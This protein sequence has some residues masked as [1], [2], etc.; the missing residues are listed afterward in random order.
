MDQ[1][2][3]KILRLIIPG[4]IIFAVGYFFFQILTNNQLKEL[5]FSEFGIQ[6]LVA[7][8]IGALY[9]TFNLR[10]IITNYTHKKI[11]LNIKNHIFKLYVG[12]L[13][14]TQIQYLF[15]QNRLKNVFYKIVDNDP[16]LVAKGKNVYFNGLLCT[17]FADSFIITFL[18]SIFVLIFTFFNDTNSEELLSYSFILFLIAIGSI[19]FHIIAFFNHTKISNTQIEFIEANYISDVK[20]IIDNI[21]R[22]NNVQ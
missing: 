8:V 13:S 10:F 20:K 15:K 22:E 19:L 16:S 4:I 1:N 3:L 21:I 18:S 6:L 17:S 12:N 11:D 5:N 14:P 2:T 7:V 9:Q